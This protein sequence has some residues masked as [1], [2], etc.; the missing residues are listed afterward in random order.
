MFGST[1]WVL[2]SIFG[3]VPNIPNNVHV[4]WKSLSIFNKKKLFFSVEGGL[5]LLNFCSQLFL[6]NLVFCMV[7]EFLGVGWIC[8]RKLRL[9]GNGLVFS[10]KCLTFS[11]LRV[12]YDILISRLVWVPN[13][14]IPIKCNTLE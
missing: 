10:S 8:T 13:Y 5:D 2:K 6:L 12:G 14:S 9:V 11:M 1:V 3:Y 7:K 4:N